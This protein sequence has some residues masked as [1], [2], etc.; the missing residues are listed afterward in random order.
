MAKTC[1]FL[2]AIFL[3]FN[4]IGCVKEDAPNPDKNT[5]ESINA[6]KHEILET[7]FRKDGELTIFSSGGDK[8]AEFAIEIASTEKAS[9][10]GLMYRESM[11]ESQA[12]FF[13]PQGLAN[14]PFWMKNTYIPLDIIFIDADNTII[15]IVENTRPFSEEKIYSNGIYRYVLEIN[16]GLAG[17]L[18]LTT[19]D[20]IIWTTEL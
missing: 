5:R 15:H 6:E 9:M 16:A 7:E 3:L 20:K 12:M 18:G 19:G 1:I 8:K 17:K 13:D 4:L 10:Q 14:T 2:I 11:E